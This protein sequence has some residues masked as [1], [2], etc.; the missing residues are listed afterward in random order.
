MAFQIT[1]K[2][3]TVESVVKGKARYQTANVAYEY[4]GE[5]RTQK[6]VS[7]S[8]PDVFAK[9]QSL[10]AGD[11]VSVETTKNEKGYDQWS[12]ISPGGDAAGGR[13][14]ASNT[15]PGRVTG[16]NYET[17]QERADNR[18]RIVRQSSI[19]NAIA[20]LVAQKLEFTSDDVLEQ[21][22][23]YFDWVYASSNDSE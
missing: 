2:E 12:K 4:K 1:I 7:F 15:S 16:S 6:L 22:Q 19:S 17:P 21:A 18:I 5:P 13:D 10:K 14:S 8:N 20:T 23:V 3:V 9:V 11:V